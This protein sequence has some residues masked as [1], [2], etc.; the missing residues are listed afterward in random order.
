MPPYAGNEDEVDTSQQTRK[1]ISM[2]VSTNERIAW[3]FTHVLSALVAGD[4]RSGAAAMMA[5]A[6]V[7]SHVVQPG[8]ILAH[9]SLRE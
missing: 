3:E 6:E 7:A 8:P 2:A 9:A 5:M 1:R 4:E